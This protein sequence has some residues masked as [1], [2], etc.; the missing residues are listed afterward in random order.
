MTFPPDTPE[1]TKACNMLR[2][3]YNREY[4]RGWRKAVAYVKCVLEQQ[5]LPVSYDDE[6]T[7]EHVKA[8]DEKLAPEFAAGD[9]KT[10]EKE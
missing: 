3:I 8:I 7:A 9:W 1:L 5:P 2:E 4:G 10:I 6:V